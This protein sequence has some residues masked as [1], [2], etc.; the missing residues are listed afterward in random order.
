MIS[1]DI[2]NETSVNFGLG[3]IVGLFGWFFGGLDGFFKVLLTFAII[4]YFSGLSVAIFVNHNLSSSV[5]FKGI[6][7]KCLM[8]SFVGIA[9]ILDK[10]LLGGTRALRTAVCLFYIGNEGISVIENADALGVPFPQMLK[11]RF[12]GLKENKHADKA[13]SKKEAKRYPKRA[14]KRSGREASTVPVSGEGN[15]E[16]SVEA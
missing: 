1:G 13:G 3:A 7:K 12:L 6:T 14:P 16:D 15:N 5:G 9:H 11:D 2:V 10:Y 8:F 4:D